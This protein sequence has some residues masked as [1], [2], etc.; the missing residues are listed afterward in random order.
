[1]SQTQQENSTIQTTNST[2]RSKEYDKRLVFKTW[3]YYNG[4]YFVRKLCVVFTLAELKYSYSNHFK[5]IFK[6]I[7]SGVGRSHP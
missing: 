6:H 1:M 3:Q 5:V 2:L 7:R 4:L